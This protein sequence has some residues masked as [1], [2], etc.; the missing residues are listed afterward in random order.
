MQHILFNDGVSSSIGRHYFPH[1]LHYW[2]GHGYGLD[3]WFLSSY[4]HEMI[5]VQEPFLDK[6]CPVLVNTLELYCK[7]H[8]HIASSL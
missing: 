4:L 2:S 5:P 6:Q 3:F 7:E 1:T 8:Y